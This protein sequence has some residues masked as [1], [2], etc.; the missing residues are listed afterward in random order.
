MVKRTMLAAS[1]LLAFA[2]PAAAAEGGLE[3]FPDLVAILSSGKS[4]LGSHFLQLILLFVLLIVP[5]NRFVLTPLLGVLEQRAVRIEGARK[6]AGEVGVQADAALARYSA[7]VEQARRQ[8]GE[9]RKQA[10]EGARGDQ[11]RILA[12][13]RR[14][15]ESEVAAARGSMAS[16]LVEARGVL[17][18]QSEG[19]AR[20]A[21]ARVLGRSLS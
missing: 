19:L 17:R 5:V 6:R 2:T 7:A 1:L 20:E 16:A 21:A 10:L 13:A 15:A 9:L 18:T 14:A 12:D 11:V 4:P 8:A 3:I